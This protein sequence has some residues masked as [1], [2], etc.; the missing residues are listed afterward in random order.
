MVGG[1]TAVTLDIATA[2][3][4]DRDATPGSS[5]KT[6]IISREPRHSVGRDGP[7]DRLLPAA[8]GGW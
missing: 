6:R 7:G 2:A 8:E 3:D 1:N 4:H 5:G